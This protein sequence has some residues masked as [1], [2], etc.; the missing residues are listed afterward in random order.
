MEG[1]APDGCN[2]NPAA[3]AGQFPVRANFFLWGLSIGVAAWGKL[4]EGGRLE[5]RQLTLQRLRHLRD[6]PDLAS[7][8]H[9]TALARLPAQ[10]QETWRQFGAEVG[11]LAGRA[12]AAR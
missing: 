3:A 2:R 7:L 5:A 4:G 6:D 11:A 8:S 12:G 9:P 1:E 10:E